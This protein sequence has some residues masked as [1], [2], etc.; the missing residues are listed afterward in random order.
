MEFVIGLPL[1][2]NKKDSVWVVVDRLTK[3]AHFILVRTDFSV[4]KLAKL[5]ISEIVRLHGKLHEAFGSRLDFST[6]FHPQ[7]NE[8][9]SETEDKVWLIW[10]RLK[11]A[12][13]RQ[14]SF[15]DLKR[16]G[17][18]FSVEDLAFLKVSPWNKVLKFGHKGKLSPQFIGP[19]QILKRVGPV[20]YQL[21]LPPEKSIPLVKVLWWNH[22][23]EETTWEL[24]KAMRQ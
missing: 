24:E 3:S 15:A 13:D 17:I 1:A 18:E 7:T 6:A 14:K 22:S 23:T 2:P 10:E 19:Y 11:A 8:L 21:E 4:Q 16:K 9:I 20:V 12:S 5:Y